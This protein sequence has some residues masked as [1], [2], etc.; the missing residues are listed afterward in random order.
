MTVKVPEKTNMDDL[1]V[2]C[3]PNPKLIVLSNGGL[4]KV[5]HKITDL[6]ISTE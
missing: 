6:G 5:R 1:I 2:D 4:R 3:F